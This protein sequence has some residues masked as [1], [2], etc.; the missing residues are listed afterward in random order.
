[1]KF[2]KLVLCILPTIM[3]VS[4]CGN[5]ASK[6]KGGMTQ[7]GTSGLAYRTVT[8]LDGGEEKQGYSLTL[9]ASQGNYFLNSQYSSKKTLTPILKVNGKEKKVEDYECYWFVEDCSIDTT[10]EGYFPL[11]GLGWKCLNK[12]TIFD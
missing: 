9:V 2:N 3:L 4:A 8:Y 10:S 7:D 6:N 11:G 1:M 5:N 12:K